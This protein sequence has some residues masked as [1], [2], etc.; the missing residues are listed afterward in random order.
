[1]TAA[2]AAAPFLATTAVPGPDT[3]ALAN[4]PLRP[5]TDPRTLSRFADDRWILTPALHEAHAN[6]TCVE[7]STVPEPFRHSV[8]LITWLMINHDADEVVAFHARASRPAIRSIVSTVRYLRM[9]TDWL[10]T[11]GITSFAE[12]S[13]A[14]LDAYVADVRASQVSHELRE[15]LLAAVARTWT[16]RHLLPEPHRLPEAPPWGGERI[17]DLLGGGRSRDE[18]RTPR[19]HPAT[20]TALLSWCLRFVEDLADDIIAAF[21]EHNSLLNR[22]P[23]RRHTRPPQVGPRRSPN[24][25]TEALIAVFDRYRA[26]DMGLP[27]QRM[28]DGTLKVNHYHLGRLVD[29]QITARAH[30]AVIAAS[31]LPI[32]DDCYLFTP[33]RACIDG[34]P[35]RDRPIT[36]D[37]APLLARHLSTACFVVIA[38]L[39]GQRPGEALNLQRGCIE[40]DQGLIYLR[41]RHWKGVRDS[42]GAAQAEGAERA[43]PWVVVAPVAAAVGVLERLHPGLLLFPN[44]LLTNGRAE[45]CLQTRVG[46]GRSDQLLTKDITA[47]TSW[48][49]AYCRTNGRDDTIPADPVDTSITTSRLRRTLA[50][51]IVR[52]PRG[53]VAAAIQYGH[54]AVRATLGYSGSYASGFPDDLAF[55]EWL[56]RL[57]NMAEAHQ[58]L[59]DGEHISGPAADAYRHRV[60]AATRFAGRTLRTRREAATL[61]ANPD[62]QI[63]TGKGMTCVFDPARAAC[64]TTGDER[65]LRR[66][67]DIDDCRPNCA[68]IARTDRDISILRAQAA[69]L[70]LIVDDPAAPPVRH[71]R[72]QHE[73]AR[74]TGLIDQHERPGAG[75]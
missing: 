17:R 28:P 24:S 4:R 37:Q 42:T 40:H 8:K 51:F 57:E 47:L 15:D 56:L 19:I 7:H 63:Y 13:Q 38:Y 48:I 5:G 30:N 70:R 44:T 73:L 43:D 11:R 60:T 33:A 49:N 68:N 21:D 72:E 10:T 16:M 3:V 36:F 59:A 54:V 50:W 29:G 12:V 26:R 23:G 71:A 31:G 75:A 61:L 18:N 27:G 20:M 6:A 45:G 22:A 55:E 52:R 66:T 9:F 53:L 58:H 1:M 25:L 2:L 65:G 64:R 62:L 34:K 46:M 67:P 14:D 35:W 74:L 41:G 39:S 32:D 69:Q